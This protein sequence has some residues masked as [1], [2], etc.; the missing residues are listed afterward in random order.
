MCQFFFYIIKDKTCATLVDMKR[1]NKKT[2]AIIISSVIFGCVLAFT[3]FAL[4]VVFSSNDVTK[5]Q[6][7]FAIGFI[8]MIDVIFLFI[9]IYT[10]VSG[11][12][13]YKLLQKGRKRE[14]K[15]INIVPSPSSTFH[16]EMTV[17]YYGESGEKYEHIVPINVSIAKNLK[18][19]QTIECY[20][21]GETCY[22]DVEHI[23]ILK[24]PEE[25]EFEEDFN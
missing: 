5:D 10:L 22:V 25:S 7:A 14:S 12:S 19:G 6:I 1:E 4:L 23:K 3:A 2:S 8:A 16:K 20:V 21:M 15:I 9:G 17:T 11:L 13:A 18:V 24:E